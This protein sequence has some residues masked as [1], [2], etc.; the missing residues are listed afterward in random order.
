LRRS[1]VGELVLFFKFAIE[2]TV[3]D[4][5]ASSGF[6]GALMLL[7][8][9]SLRVLLR[10]TLSMLIALA[11]R[12]VL[13]LLTLFVLAALTLLPL[14]LALLTLSLLTLLLVLIHDD[15]DLRIR[16]SKR[17]AACCRVAA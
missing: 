9:L 2:T 15:G 8:G 10:L 12:T 13:G 17:D 5:A 6:A 16:I 7:R 14:L 1:P 3:R 11:R 4:A